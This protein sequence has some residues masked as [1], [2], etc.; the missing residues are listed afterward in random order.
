MPIN[1]LMEKILSESKNTSPSSMYRITFFFEV[2]SAQ[3]LSSL[4]YSA[5]RCKQFYRIVSWYPCWSLQK[6]LCKVTRQATFALILRITNYCFLTN[7]NEL[8]ISETFFYCINSIKGPIATFERDVRG[9]G[10]SFS[11]SVVFPYFL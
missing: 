7:K 10:F 3:I 11:S 9:W 2:E 8:W 5:Q 6:F 4:F 1:A